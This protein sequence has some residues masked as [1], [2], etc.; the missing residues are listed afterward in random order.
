MSLLL[1]CYMLILRYGALVIKRFRDRERMGFSNQKT[2]LPTIDK[3]RFTYPVTYTNIYITCIMPACAIFVF[4]I[5][6]NVSGAKGSDESG[7]IYRCRH[8]RS[9][10]KIRRGNKTVGTHPRTNRLLLVIAVYILRLER[11][12]KWLKSLYQKS[13]RSLSTNT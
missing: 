5:T 8:Y 12:E 3:S 13:T 6:A 2:I 10:E 7:R 11:R 9:V 1:V 4:D